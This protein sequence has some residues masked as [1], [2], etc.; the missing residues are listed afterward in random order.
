[1]S[2]R[3]RASGPDSVDRGA[4]VR[5]EYEFG[6][7]EWHPP[8]I[9]R[10]ISVDTA[11][12]HAVSPEFDFGHPRRACE[13]EVIPAGLKSRERLHE[14]RQ[15]GHDL[16]GYARL[17]AHFTRRGLWDCLARIDAASRKLYASGWI[18]L[19]C[20]DQQSIAIVKDVDDDT[21]AR[22]CSRGFHARK[23]TRRLSWN[24][25]RAQYELLVW[26]LHAEFT[27]TDDC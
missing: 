1:M 20:K 18:A 27:W 19:L 17:F 21:F 14:H 25:H 9:E 5:A 13:H 22:S 6:P 24:S 4:L 3:E 11:A 26:I 23:P 12:R 15:L 2:T 7:L 16:A 10:S 8:A